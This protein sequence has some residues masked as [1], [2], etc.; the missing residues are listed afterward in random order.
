[1]TKS[2]LK[3]FLQSH[4]D[5]VMA[6]VG[7]PAAL[8]YPLFELGALVRRL[9]SR[10][11][12][13]RRFASKGVN[14]RFDPLGGQI[15]YAKVTIGDN[16]FLGDAA[17][18]WALDH[19]A[20]GDDVMLGPD[21]YIMTGYHRINV[22]GR[23]IRESGPDDRQ[24][25]IIEDDVW[26][27]ARSTILKGVRIGQGSVIGTGSVV[28]K[29]IPPY[30]VAVGNPCRVL[31]KRFSDEDLDRHLRIM[32]TPA[33][34]IAAIINERAAAFAAPSVEMPSVGP[35]RTTDQ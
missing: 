11:V 14:A 6:A 22:I 32:D 8:A 35:R 33:A 26:I 7:P 17:R 20:I 31:R 23:T 27:G 3:S 5:R 30:V 28:G 2:Y 1:M 16:T 13:S 34:R 10:H 29:N 19:V 21:V 12:K 4:R 24:P 18:I 9:G 15:D 25:V